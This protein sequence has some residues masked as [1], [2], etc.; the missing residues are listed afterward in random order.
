M[1]QGTVKW[2]NADKG[3]GFIAVDGGRDLF[4]H[5]TAIQM[6]GFRTLAEGQRVDF[7]IHQGERGPQAIEVHISGE[8]AQETT[9]QVEN[10][11]LSSEPGDRPLSSM[12][13]PELQRL[14]QSLGIVGVGRMRKSQLIEA[15]QARKLSPEPTASAA[16]K[17]A[18]PHSATSLP[19]TVRP[20]ESRDGSLSS[21]LLPELQRLAQSLGIVSVGR[22]RK[23][24]LI[25]AIQA[26]RA[27][28]AMP[29]DWQ[30]SRGGAP[31]YQQVAEH[32]RNQI[33]SDGILRGE[34]LRTEVELQEYYGVSRNT[35]R[36][37]IKYLISQGILETRPGQGTFVIKAAEP[38]SASTSPI[39]SNQPL[40]SLQ[41]L[42]REASSKSSVI[43]DTE[44]GGF[45]INERVRKAQADQAEKEARRALARRSF[46]DAVT[47][48]EKARTLDPDR[49]ERLELELNFFSAQDDDL[50]GQLAWRR[51]VWLALA[52][53]SSSDP[54]DSSSARVAT[55]PARP[56]TATK[57]VPPSVSQRQGLVKPGK[58]GAE[59]EV[60][61]VRLLQR[62]FHLAA[63]D[64]KAILERLRRQNAG[65]Q[66][67]H[68]IQFDCRAANSSVRLHVECKNYDRPLQTHDI[69]DKILQMRTY[70][71]EKKVD[72]FVIVTP[73]AGIQNDLDRL[74]QSLNSEESAQFHIQVWGPDER[75]QELFALEPTAYKA[76][77]GTE[78][79]SVDARAIIERW[80]ARL[81]PV[82]RLPASLAS[83]LTSP[84]AH[85]VTG[86]DIQHF[87]ELFR[88]PIETQASTLAGVPLGQL[89]DVLTNWVGDT[90]RRTMLLVG[91]FGDGKSFAC[92]RLTRI[93]ASTYTSNPRSTFPLRL[94]LRDLRSAGNPQELLSRRLKVLG[95]DVRDWARVQEVAPTVVI[96]DGFDEMSAQLDHATVAE[97]LRL[98]AECVRY[99]ASSKVIVTS[100]T[101]FF[102]T[103]R[104]QD[105]FLEQ[106][107]NPDVVQ[108]TPLP[109]NKRSE[110]LNTYAKRHGLSSKFERIRRLYDPIGLAAKPLFLQ[111]IKET[112]PDLPDNDFDEVVLYETYVQKS[113]MR[114]TELLEDE[115]M[116]TLRKETLHGM[117]QLLES[118]ALEQLVTGGRP[119]DLRTFGVDRIDLARVL[120][121]MS[122][123]DASAKQ[124]QDAR[125]RLG[126]RS[127]LKPVPKPNEDEAWPVT[128][129]HRSMSEYFIARALVDA[130][131]HNQSQARNLL[132]SVI[133][134]PETVDF[135]ALLANKGHDSEALGRTLEGL[136][137]SAVRGTQ[138]NYLGGNAITLAFRINWRPPR[139]GWT[140]LELSY[141][142][143]SATDLSGADFSGS[144]LRYATLD[145]ADLSGADL[146]DCDLTG[147]RLEETAPVVNL[148]PGRV[149]DSVLACYGDGSIREWSLSGSR[150]ASK[151]ILDGFGGLKSATWGPYGDLVVID[152]HNLSLWRIAGSQTAK[153]AE[154]RIRAEAD[155]IRLAGS[156]LSFTLARRNQCTAIL[157]DCPSASIRAMVR[158]PERSSVVFA[159]D[160]TAVLPVDQGKTGIA[161]ID[162]IDLKS[163]EI[164]VEDVTAVDVRSSSDG[165]IRMIVGDSRGNVAPIR[166]DVNSETIDFDA[167]IPQRLHE[168]AVLAV[169]FLSQNVVATGG[170]D[171]S[172]TICD[173][174]H[175]ELRV[176]H[177]LVLTLRCADLKTVGVQGDRERQALEALRDKAA[178]EAPYA[179]TVE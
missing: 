164:P 13:L 171:R 121:K 46:E 38:E 8:D 175:S 60:A 144:S 16:T 172:L 118:L 88:E 116:H 76:V 173:V 125:A 158:L 133:L 26:R 143:L 156:A 85:C 47:H 98:L 22:M 109:R 58:A 150:P 39:G 174:D 34:R 70:W 102:E 10:V 18:G 153:K 135:I 112:L 100:R 96:L 129:F 108:L 50:P 2:F 165:E 97:N 136:A 148:A 140:G 62:F 77:Y 87:E 7:Q 161:R 6:D 149:E 126:V 82:L 25:E 51:G 64:E 128:F 159:N 177:R 52:A 122:E 20:Y 86:E 14:A 69:A 73:R 145:N 42:S 178:S 137:R 127:L 79:Q 114:K 110:H 95:A 68:D 83:Y 31:L 65:T 55:L 134:G 61:F 1:A 146:T 54:R 35:V 170:R 93:L 115:G 21:M 33:E 24:Q 160:R 80:T 36:D 132:S 89:G 40:K 168:G 75:I 101:H 166:A 117:V 162:G 92:Y 154:F 152:R 105:R 157:F 11:T 113:L 99:F 142:D 107:E 57:T 12:L 5:H 49:A 78:P 43:D 3:Y 106:L 120:W 131:R 151:K 104:D 81:K 32:I 90:G 71:R 141:A 169:C 119:V 28:T 111:M 155:S 147:V 19:G 59:L 176:A 29:S 41:P 163:R 123:V 67:G 56:E 63:E 130:L 23:S 37:A 45:A 44:H 48:L 15:I 53:G 91:E 4:V 103:N 27:G 84:H 138:S 74:I 124:T 17:N 72:H 9:P 66:F 179:T 30:A 167:P 139:R 94:P